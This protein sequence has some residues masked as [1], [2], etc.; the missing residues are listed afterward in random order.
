MNKIHPEGL[1]ESA[2]TN[3]RSPDLSEAQLQQIKENEIKVLSPEEYNLLAANDSIE[4]LQVF[5]ALNNT[6]GSQS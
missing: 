1:K 2:K 4:N 3:D 6:G 5:E